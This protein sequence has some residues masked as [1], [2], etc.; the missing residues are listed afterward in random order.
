[1]EIGRISIIRVSIT[2]NC[3]YLYIDFMKGNTIHIIFIFWALLFLFSCNTTNKDADPAGT[4]FVVDTNFKPKT[5]TAAIKPINISALDLTKA[6]IANEVKADYDYKQ[7]NLIVEG[8]VEDIK[9]GSSDQVFVV[10]KG[11]ERFTSVQCYLT[12]GTEAIPLKKEMKAFL[13]GQCDG[14][15]VNVIL[16]DC[17]LIKQPK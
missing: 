7:R 12:D 6:Y 2:R 8:V 3:F 11:C 13:K 4:N 17:T 15:N 16:H 5:D 14:L 10:L 9:V 1:M